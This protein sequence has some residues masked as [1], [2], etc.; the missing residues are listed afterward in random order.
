MTP[1]RTYVPRGPH[2]HEFDPLSGWCAHCLT[3]D[4][5]LV[6]DYSGRTIRHPDTPTT[7]PGPN[8]LDW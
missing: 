5:G 2:A 3:R 6:L 7:A 1:R 4:D 8:E